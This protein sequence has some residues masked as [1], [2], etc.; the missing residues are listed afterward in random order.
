MG[1]MGEFILKDKDRSEGWRC[2]PVEQNY[3]HQK[4][5]MNVHTHICTAKTSLE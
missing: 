3:I 2:Q 1:P 4:L 5:N